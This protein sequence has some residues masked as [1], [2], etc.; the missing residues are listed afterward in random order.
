MLAVL[1]RVIL[2]LPEVI[3]PIVA[4]VVSPV[5]LVLSSTEFTSSDEL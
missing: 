3:L 2:K 4:V 5:K 1:L